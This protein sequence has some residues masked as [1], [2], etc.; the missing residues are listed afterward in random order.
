[1][2][3]S[4]PRERAPHEIA[5]RE[6]APVLRILPSNW[7]FYELTGGNGKIVCARVSDLILEKLASL[8]LFLAIFWGGPYVEKKFSFDPLKGA[9]KGRF[10]KKIKK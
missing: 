3:E 9:Q 6:K 5:P 8:I 1:M 4:A 7:V 10:L 2:H